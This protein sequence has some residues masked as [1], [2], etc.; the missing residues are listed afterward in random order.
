M[1]QQFAVKR[2][3]SRP[4]SVLRK[5]REE[6]RVPGVV[7]GYNQENTTV[8]MDMG[9]LIRILQRQGTASVID[10]ELEGNK[11]NVMISELQRDRLKDRIIHVDFKI[12]NMKEP[13]DTEIGIHLEGE[14]TGVKEGGILQHQARTVHIRC[15][16]EHIPDGISYDISELAIGDSV[17]VGDLQVPAQVEVLSEAEEVIASILP[18]QV[19]QEAEAE[20]LDEAAA[21]D[22]TQDEAG[23]DEDAEEKED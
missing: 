23:A 10:L 19:E 7:Y 1:A 2:R 14:A 16:P 17:S 8:D 4:R 11:H 20:A 6:G 13:I 9:E 5:L 22:A 3:E 21:A 18:P 15:L 12:V